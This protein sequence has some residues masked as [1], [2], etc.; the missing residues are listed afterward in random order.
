MDKTWTPWL[1]WENGPTE[2]LVRPEKIVEEYMPAQFFKRPDKRADKEGH[3][4]W[5]LDMARLLFKGGYPGP[6]LKI[7]SLKVEPLLGVWPPR[8]HTALYG[9]ESGEEKEIRRLMLAFAQRCFRRPVELGEIEPCISG[10]EQAA[11]R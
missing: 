6:H 8:S 9:A 10:P 3:E 2:R 7:H 11:P 5:G 4:N 1:G